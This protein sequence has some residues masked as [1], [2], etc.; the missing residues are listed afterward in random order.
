MLPAFVVLS[1]SLR[2][3]LTLMVSIPTFMV[4][5]LHRSV[6]LLSNIE[7][8]R[9][10]KLPYLFILSILNRALKTLSN[11][12]EIFDLSPPFRETEGFNF[13]SPP[14]PNSKS[15]SLLLLR[16]LLQHLHLCLFHPVSYWFCLHHF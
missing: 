8:L 2:R 9:D 11:K 14:H 16:Q 5:T 13:S 3:M 15:R 12:K 10:S 4:G 7:P 6:I 1:T